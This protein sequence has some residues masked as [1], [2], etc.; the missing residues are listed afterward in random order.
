MK[1][2]LS[3]TYKGVAEFFPSLFHIFF[4]RRDKSQSNQ[5]W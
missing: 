4:K 5:N 1:D 2:L 3:S